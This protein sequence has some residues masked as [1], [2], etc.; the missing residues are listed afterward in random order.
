MIVQVLKTVDIELGAEWKSYSDHLHMNE[1]IAF[2][3]K[4]TEEYTPYTEARKM[5]AGWLWRIPTFG[6][7][8]NGYVYNNNL[9]TVDKPVEEVEKQYEHDIDV[10]K[11]VNFEQGFR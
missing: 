4:D 7:W 1:A 10:V 11:N 8:G 3:T 6:R 9:I 2:P 5:S